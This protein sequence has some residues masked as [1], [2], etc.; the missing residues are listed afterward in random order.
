MIGFYLKLLLKR[1]PAAT[2][3]NDRLFSTEQAFLGI[4]FLG[5]FMFFLHSNM[6]SFGDAILGPDNVCW[7]SCTMSETIPITD[8]WFCRVF[9]KLQINKS[10]QSKHCSVDP[11]ESVL[12]AF[13][14]A[15]LLPASVDQFGKRFEGSVRYPNCATS[16]QPWQCCSLPRAWPNSRAQP[17]SSISKLRSHLAVHLWWWHSWSGTEMYDRARSRTG[18]EGADGNQWDTNEKSMRN[19]WETNGPL[20]QSRWTQIK[21]RS[22]SSIAKL[23]RLTNVC[24]FIP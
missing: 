16:S 24:L 21:A 1:S 5:S 12:R 2:K 8:D 19:Q 6:F 11:L 3:L 10:L 13:F 7:T 23:V 9:F 4:P 15:T 14:K 20:V 22:E 18:G 17:H